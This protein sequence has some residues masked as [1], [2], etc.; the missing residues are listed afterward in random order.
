MT[1]NGTLK[2]GCDERHDVRF[3]KRWRCLL[4]VIFD[5]MRRSYDLPV[6]PN[7]RKSDQ[8]SFVDTSFELP[9]LSVERHF[10]GVLCPWS[11]RVRSQDR[12]TA[13][14]IDLSRELG[15]AAI[16]TFG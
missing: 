13:K 15:A 10:V 12:W 16:G 5:E 9:A 6:V 3:R 14:S 2:D 1:S 8:L 7:K 11:R 4:R